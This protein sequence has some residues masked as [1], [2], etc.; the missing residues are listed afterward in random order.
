MKNRIIKLLVFDFDGTALGGHTP[1]DQFPRPFAKFLDELHRSGIRWATNTT[2][3]PDAQ[4]NV[5]KRSGVKSKPAFLTGQ[6]GRSMATVENNRLVT[7]VKHEKMVLSR[8]KRFKRKHWPA[9]RGILLSLL[10]KD[11]L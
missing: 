10:Q 7:D 9:I 5:I 3:P 4:F 1:Y 11:S 2:W 6:T 8:D